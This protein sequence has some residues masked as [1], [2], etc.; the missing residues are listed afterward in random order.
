MDLAFLNE[1]KDLDARE[2]ALAT[3]ERTI[4]ARSRAEQRQALRDARATL[5]S[6]VT[7]PVDWRAAVF[8]DKEIWLASEAD[9]LRGV[10][11][12]LLK[13]TLE[14]VATTAK[15]S[16]AEAFDAC[17]RAP[18]DTLATLS[19]CLTDDVRAMARVVDR[20]VDRLQ[21][22]SSASFCRG[23]RRPS[24]RSPTAARASKTSSMPASAVAPPRTVVMPAVLSRDALNTLIRSKGL[25]GALAR[26]RSGDHRGPRQAH[27]GR[28]RRGRRGPGS[29]RGSDTPS[30][31]DDLT[32]PTT[33]ER[34]VDQLALAD[35]AAPQ[36][37]DLPFQPAADLSRVFASSNQWLNRARRRYRYWDDRWKEL[38]TCPICWDALPKAETMGS[39]LGTKLCAH[40][41][42]VCVSCAREHCKNHL[43]DSSGITEKGLPCV[44]WGCSTPLTLDALAATFTVMRGHGDGD[45]YPTPDQLLRPARWP[46]PSASCAPR[47]SVLLV[48]RPAGARTGA[49]TRSSISRARRPSARSARRSFASRVNR[50]GTTGPAPPPRAR[51]T[52]R[53]GAVTG[54]VVPAARRSWRRRRPAAGVLREAIDA[55]HHYHS[56]IARATTCGAGAV[57]RFCYNCGARGHGCPTG[58]KRPRVF[59]P[60]RT[61]DRSTAPTAPPT[62]ND[63]SA[64]ARHQ[65]LRAPLKD[66]VYVTAG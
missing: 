58:G 26:R 34:Y 27:Q 19:A 53:Y 23:S 1:G 22:S 55:T 17:R 60:P 42:E 16:Y 18:Q 52:K 39:H 5:G 15:C 64:A 29:R 56:L 28:L 61:S 3:A 13:L 54:S 46:K 41:D 14:T 38:R 59:D 25:R 44:E 35:G 66:A 24:G 12:K 2:K 62:G 33:L 4:A 37:D 9:F 51:S 49:R 63:A 32:Q 50:S 43:A 48:E 45:A 65:G 57:Q 7:S 21:A 8:D 20:A 10:D 6:D 40:F 36:G 11:C 47:R 30:A 31:D